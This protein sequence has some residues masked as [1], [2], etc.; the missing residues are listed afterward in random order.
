MALNSAVRA[1]GVSSFGAVTSSGRGSHFFRGWCGLFRDGFLSWS[2]IF[3]VRQSSKCEG[4]PPPK[5]CLS[6]E[7][8]GSYSYR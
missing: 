7:A 2:A 8:T 6:I 5:I 1:W 4:E 3:A